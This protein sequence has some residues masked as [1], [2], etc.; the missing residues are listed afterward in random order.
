MIQMHSHGTMVG[1]LRL[2]DMFCVALLADLQYLKLIARYR[3][4]FNVCF[5]CQRTVLA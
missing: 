1:V 4:I 2:D 5:L 3:L